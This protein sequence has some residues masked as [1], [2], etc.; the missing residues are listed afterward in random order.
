MI[1]KYYGDISHARVVNAIKEYLIDAITDE[2][3]ERIEF[4][5]D[6]VLNYAEIKIKWLIYDDKYFCEDEFEE[7]DEILNCEMCEFITYEDA[8]E[9]AK[10]INKI[11][12]IEQEEKNYLKIYEEK[13]DALY[14][15]FK[16]D[17]DIKTLTGES[18]GLVVLKWFEKKSS[19][20]K[21]S[22]IFEKKR[23]HSDYLDQKYAA[24]DNFA[25]SVYEALSFL[26]IDTE[27]KQEKNKN[28]K[29]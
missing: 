3:N 5:A 6:A 14:E 17:L 11:F 10:E 15:D 13:E 9:V 8:E 1:K 28:Y 4:S 24:T 16:K 22:E 2:G 21:F 20:L 7:L 19:A 29:A 26:L 18:G 12:E 23:A 27:I 25:K